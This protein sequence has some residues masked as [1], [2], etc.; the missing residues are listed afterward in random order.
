MTYTI[1]AKGI[2]DVA[3]ADDYYWKPIETC[4][5]KVKVLL[6]SV[7]GIATLSPYCGDPNGHWVAWA[8]LPRIP[9]TL[10]PG[11]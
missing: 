10:K 1:K 2:A 11:F 4:P 8:P 3:V 7:G 5:T 9:E 6:L